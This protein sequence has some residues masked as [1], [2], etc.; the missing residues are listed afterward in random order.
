MTD[1][2]PVA[3]FPRQFV[4]CW[5]LQRPACAE[6]P[7]QAG[8]LPRGEPPERATQPGSDEWQALLAAGQLLVASLHGHLDDR[9][10]VRP[11]P[12]RHRLVERHP[13]CSQVADVLGEDA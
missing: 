7:A 3:D 4:T 10:G 6:I 1:G 13:T 5:P 12:G 9:G 8:M 2:Y 11:G